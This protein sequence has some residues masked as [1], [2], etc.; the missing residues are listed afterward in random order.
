MKQRKCLLNLF[1]ALFLCF[2]IAQA[3]EEW[4]ACF[5]FAGS[6]NSSLKYMVNWRSPN[7]DANPVNLGL[8]RFVNSIPI[9]PSLDISPATRT[10]GMTL[11][12]DKKTITIVSPQILNIETEYAADSKFG[13]HIGKMSYHDINNGNAPSTGNAMCF[14]ANS[15]DELKR[16]IGDNAARTPTFCERYGTTIAGIA[17]GTLALLA[18]FYCGT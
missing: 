9:P 13:K 3:E 11:G 12:G 5:Y 1:V 17:A 8:T 15:N 16:M 7:T 18:A 10:S 14:I 4:G 6:D 2:G